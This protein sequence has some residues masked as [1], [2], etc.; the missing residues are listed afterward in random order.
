[1]SLVLALS[2]SV[3]FFAGICFGIFGTVTAEQRAYTRYLN[4]HQRARIA[5][6]EDVQ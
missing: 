5:Y 2:L 1:M 3:A 6:A 4:A